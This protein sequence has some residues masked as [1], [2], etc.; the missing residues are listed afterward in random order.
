MKKDFTLT[1]P[2][3]CHEKWEHFT[4]TKKGRFCGACQKAVIDFTSWDAEQIKQYFSHHA[5]PVCGRFNASQL[6]TYHPS[7]SVRRSWMPASL[8][9]L[10]LLL[11]SRPTEAQPQRNVAQQEQVEERRPIVHQTDSVIKKMIITG[12]VRDAVDT[13][14]VP[15]VNVVRKGT[16]EQVV[17]D[18]NGWFEIIIANPKTM[19][20][21]EFSFIGFVIQERTFKATASTSAEITLE[22]DVIALRETVIMG[23]VCATPWYSPR[24]VW[25]WMKNGFRHY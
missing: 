1:V 10:L 14:R 8:V 6:T 22:Q 17:T 16:E 24:R 23:G 25:W 13:S 18:V 5:Q 3:P 15:G 21:L 7:S 4:P 12:V 19:E 20:T 2:K 11:V 9:A